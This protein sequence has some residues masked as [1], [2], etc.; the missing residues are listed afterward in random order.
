MKTFKTTKNLVRNNKR[1]GNLSVPITRGGN[2]CHGS[3]IQY[4]YNNKSASLN[5]I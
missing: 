4:G 1:Q 2:M 5:F 3:G